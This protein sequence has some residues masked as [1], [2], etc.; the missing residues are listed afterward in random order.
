MAL[1]SPA[2]TN[3]KVQRIF[4]SMCALLR[5]IPGYASLPACSRGRKTHW[6]PAARL[7]PDAKDC[8]RKS[9][10]TSRAAS[11]R[12]DSDQYAFPHDCTLE[13]MRTQGG[14]SFYCFDGECLCRKR[15]QI[16]L[17]VSGLCVA[18]DQKAGEPSRGVVERL[19]GEYAIFHMSYD[20]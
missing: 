14:I 18:C 11:V 10:D 15:R 20:I 4:L 9:L 12:S 17:P 13:A 19:R 7:W 5:M 6:R 2:T 3:N 1:A 16:R 8:N